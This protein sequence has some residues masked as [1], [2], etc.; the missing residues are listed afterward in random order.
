[1]SPNDQTVSAEVSAAPG[2]S[3]NELSKPAF[4]HAEVEILPHFLPVGE[5]RQVGEGRRDTEI[6]RPYL[7]VGRIDILDAPREGQPVD[8]RIALV[9]ELLELRARADRDAERQ[10]PA[11][12]RR[13]GQIADWKRPQ[14]VLLPEPR[15]FIRQAISAFTRF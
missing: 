8:V 6:G 10:A 3:W 5:G 12:G 15:W 1:M 7:I 11:N 14:E 13:G 4:L 2:M 9:E